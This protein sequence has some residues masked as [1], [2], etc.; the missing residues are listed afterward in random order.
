MTDA[1]TLN[2]GRPPSGGGATA[3]AAPDEAP[4]APAATPAAPGNPGS[5]PGAPLRGGRRVPPPA[6]G[7]EATAGAAPGV[8]GAAPGATPA[9]PDGHR[10][11][12][13]DTDTG[14]DGFLKWGSGI[15]LA[16]LGVIG[17]ALSYRT[18]L[19]FAE[20]NDFGDFAPAFPIGID[21][22]IVIL[23]VRDLYLV[24]HQARWAVLR[25]LAHALTLATVAFNAA[26]GGLG[27]PLGAAAHGIMPILFIVGIESVRREL[28]KKALQAAGKDTESIP[29]HR[30]LL[31]PW[32]SAKLYRRMRL[33]GV[34]SYSEMIRRDK[35]L[36]GY[37]VWLSMH[38]ADKK[39]EATEEE[40]L[41]MRMAPYGYTVDEALA[42][43]AQ[44]RAEA[45]ERE[46]QR[47]EEQRAEEA[48]EAEHRRA[49]AIRREE[50]AKQDRL[51]AIRTRAEVATAEHES[52]A[53]V[54]SAEAKAERRRFEAERTRL[55]AERTAKA[56]EEVVLSEGAAAAKRRTA[57]HEA[58][59]A[60]AEADAEAERRR[61]EEERARA[62]RAAADK[63]KA[64]ADKVKAEEA[65]RAAA[66]A[67]ARAEHEAAVRR[68]Q[69]AEIEARAQAAEDYARLSTRQR[70]VYWTARRI[71]EAGGV[72]HGPTG[73][74]VS[75]E[76]VP[77]T[78]IE[79]GQKMSRSAAGEIR[80]AAV[81]LLESGFD[82]ATAYVPPVVHDLPAV[83]H[84]QDWHQD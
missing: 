59:T 64:A 10:S 24:R 36:R 47:M 16:L 41:P 80:A 71:W 11:A 69:A 9:T 32:S 50:E 43:P 58:Q 54:I 84:M 28:R 77:L 81:E 83:Q 7:R 21:I 17:F 48:R 49:E 67:A 57:E 38:L 61:F 19:K 44:W 65:Q 39:R 53:E 25:P 66:A 63:A 45:A 30:W 40:T 29:L 3:G 14:G 6:T 15:G 18:L 75:T 82:P 55:L 60:K 1:Q 76:V 42:L 73:I 37:E 78:D 27:S 12:P 2:S 20:N 79:A 31:A 35:D 56:E 74:Q 34:T 72:Q 8:A 26:E 52:E 23:L 70:R 5:A 68:A 33:A 62:E 4:A 51:R 46:R 13:R 22:G